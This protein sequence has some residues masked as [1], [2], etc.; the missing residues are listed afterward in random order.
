MKN[1]AYSGSRRIGIDLDDTL[2]DF[3]SAL[4]E[5]HNEECRTSLRRDDFKSYSLNE[6]LG[7]T[8]EEINQKMND[9]YNSGYFENIQPIPGAIAAIEKLSKREELFLI[10]SRPDFLNEKTI[11]SLNRFFPGK[12]LDIIHSINH[13]SKRKNSGKSKVE[14]CRD[15]GA[16]RLIDDSLDYIMQCLET[17]EVRGLLFGNYPWNQLNGLPTNI[18]RVKNWREALEKI[19]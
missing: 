1:K 6:T 9:F 2:V 15:L 4:R 14:I 5:W 3:N 11:E 12:F 16:S 8:E 7:E 10:T 18:I 19:A 17:G 13:Y